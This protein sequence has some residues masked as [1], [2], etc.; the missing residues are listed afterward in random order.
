MLEGW[1]VVAIFLGFI[2]L[3]KKKSFIWIRKIQVL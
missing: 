3:L 1:T 2:N